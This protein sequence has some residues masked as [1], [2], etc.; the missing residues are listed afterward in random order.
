MFIKSISGGEKGSSVCVTLSDENSG[1][2]ERLFISRK[3]WSVMADE[4]SALLPVDEQ[5]YDKLKSAA[6]KTAALREA[7][8]M[9]GSGEKSRRE[10]ERRLKARKIPDSAAKWAVAVLEKNGYLDEESSCARIA[11]SAVASKHYGKRRVLEYLLSHGYEKGAAIAAIEAIPPDEYRAALEYNLE[12]KYPNAAE[13]DIK[14]RQK[15]TAA[16]M[17]LG[18]SGGEIADA[19]RDMRA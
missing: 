14:E 11:E 6:D 10:L 2:V 3:L 15:I 9:I 19:I 5:L 4:M 12:H 16:L 7:S 13:C 1:G 17:R 8:R 18:F